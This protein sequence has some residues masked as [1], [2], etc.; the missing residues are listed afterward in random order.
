MVGDGSF[1]SFFE[2]VRWTQSG[3][4]VGLGLLPGY[5]FSQANA[6]NAGLGRSREFRGAFRWTQSGGMVSLG[7][8]PGGSAYGV[9]ADGL[10]V[11]G[12]AGD[13]AFRW[14][15]SGGLV[16]LGFLPGVR[17]L[18]AHSVS[19]TNVIRAILISIFV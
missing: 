6:L 17:I 3:G 9:S 13:Q 11:V 12:L 8:P 5:M 15:P 1:A 10:V 16:G 18:V 2:A 7:T 14:T 19:T 4:I